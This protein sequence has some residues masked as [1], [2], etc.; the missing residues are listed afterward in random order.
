MKRLF[1]VCLALVLLLCSCSGG[2]KFKR[3]QDGSGYIDTKTDL[4]YTMLDVA[5]QPAASGEIVGEYHDRERDI[6]VV[7]REIPELDPTRF[8]AD[9]DL[10]VY[11]AGETL[12]NA[13]EWRIKEILVCEGDGIGVERARFVSGEDE[14]AVS[15][16]RSLWFEGEEANFLSLKEA[17]K[18]Y[19]IKIASV[20]YP[21]LY[22]S[23]N[24]LYFEQGECYFHNA[25]I[26]RSVVVPTD[27]VELL[28]AFAKEV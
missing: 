13:A 3:T 8:L 27:L 19:S 24:F 21:N 18:R 9:E 23:F 1:V 2:H 10:N 17:D 11:F 26:G 14:Q 25:V 12:P 6:T 4:T 15:R 16:I 5:F 7:F 22:Y 20:D 28:R